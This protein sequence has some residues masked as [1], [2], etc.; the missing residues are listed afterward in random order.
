MVTRHTTFKFQKV[1]DDDVLV[2]P[3]CLQPVI[4]SK[5]IVLAVDL[6][7]LRPYVGSVPRLKLQCIGQTQTRYSR[8]ILLC[9]SLLSRLGRMEKIF[10]A[11]ASIMEYPCHF[12]SAKKDDVDI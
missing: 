4:I 8:G 1:D 11:H 5:F 3:D 12:Y 9:G 7:G 6:L 10:E 2:T